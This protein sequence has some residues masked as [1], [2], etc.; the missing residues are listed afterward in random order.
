MNEFDDLLKIGRVAELAGVSVA[1][2]KYYVREGLLPQPVKAR[3]NMAYYDKSCVDIILFIKRMQ[4]EKFLPLAAIKRIIDSGA[5]LDEEVEVGGAIFKSHQEKTD[6]PPIKESQIESGLG[7]PIDK[8]RLLE[9][10]GLIAPASHNGERTYGHEDQKIIEIMKARD[11]LGVPFEY[12]IDMLKNYHRAMESAVEGDLGQ[13]FRDPMEDMTIEKLV[14]LLT[15]A[16]KILDDYIVMSR[17]RLVR[18]LSEKALKELND[19]SAQINLLNP[20]PISSGFLPPEPPSDYMTAFAYYLCRGEF[21][22]L[23]KAIP[24]GGPNRNA[25]SILAELF[26]SRP[27]VALEQA[28]TLIPSPTNNILDN[29]AAAAAYLYSLSEKA[30]LSIIL[31]HI[32]KLLAFLRRIA[33]GE[34]RNTP[35]HIF[36][37]FFCAASLIMLPGV[38]GVRQR[39]LDLLMELEGVLLDERPVIESE[40]DWLTWTWDLEIVPR[41]LILINRFSAQALISSGRAREAYSVLGKLIELADLESDHSKWARL[42]RVR[43]KPLV[44][45]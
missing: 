12:S 42:E 6:L 36:I 35:L 9:D 33:S 10:Y 3:R 16:D 17:Y 45:N 28:E 18:S 13:F 15:D 26:N 24:K 14:R 1:A 39:G 5:P 43:L 34:K 38:V 41:L 31:F 21:E 20:F 30:G 44:K 29:A 32:Q 27:H 4:K 11:E 19:L 7:Y 8:I 40:P 22:N 23:H 25:M 2:V 37:R